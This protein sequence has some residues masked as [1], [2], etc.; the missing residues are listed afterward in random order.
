MS[1]TAASTRPDAVIFDLDGT[2]VD[3]VERRIEAW[4]RAFEGAGIPAT[5]EAI[6]PLIGSDGKWLA[7][8]IAKAAGKP[9]SEEQV[10]ETDR[11]S[12]EI[13]QALNLDPRPLPGAREL[14]NTLDRAGIPWAIAT[15]SR[16]EQV[17]ASV[18]ALRL[19]HDPVIVDS[20]HV[21][22]AKP[23]PDL[24]LL[25]AR[26]LRVDPRR[27]WYVGDS[28]F[29]MRAAAAAGMHPIGVVTGSANGADLRKAG[30][31]EVVP[32]LV[33]LEERVRGWAGLPSSTA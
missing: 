10:E 5:R 9:L 31:V 15:S 32:S 20:S 7:R 13:Y 17:H 16:R 18:D 1:T 4:L 29:D 33:A 25:A 23:E 2:L 27:T 30:A 11:R 19:Q 8:R 6:S 22:R 24:L 28:T 21:E 3:T 26:Q 14:A 12:G